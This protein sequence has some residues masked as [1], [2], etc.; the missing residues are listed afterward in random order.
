[1][2]VALELSSEQKHFQTNHKKILISLGTLLV[3]IWMPKYEWKAQKEVRSII[4]KTYLI[5]YPN[6]HE[7]TVCKNMDVHYQREQANM[8]MR[9]IL[10]ETGRRG[11][12]LYN[13]CRKF[14]WMCPTVMWKSELV[15]GWGDFQA[16]CWRFSLV[17][18]CCFQE[19]VR[20]K[21]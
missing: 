20:V 13:S 21:R 1:M 15:R 18:F 7:Q 5:E 10:L 17:S 2:E 14:S 19:N 9:T 16:K 12:F 6:H 3:K 8:E 4:E 11:S